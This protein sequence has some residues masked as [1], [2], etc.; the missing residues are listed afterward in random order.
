MKV[1]LCQRGKVPLRQKQIKSR[2]LEGETEWDNGGTG[3]M[4]VR[5]VTGR[6]GI[7]HQGGGKVQ[8]DETRQSNDPGIG[9]GG[10]WSTTKNEDRREE[11][12]AIGRSRKELKG[13]GSV[14]TGKRC[15]VIREG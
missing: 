7:R 4:E 6:T 11:T 2:H 5:I 1:P 13:M 10:K 12:V 14:G 9:M 8:T 3:G 15:G